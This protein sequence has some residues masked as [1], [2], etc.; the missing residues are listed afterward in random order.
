MPV[1]RDILDYF[2]KYHLPLQ[3]DLRKTFLKQQQERNC[4]KQKAEKDR[5]KKATNWQPK[6]RKKW[7]RHLNTATDNFVI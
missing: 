6:Q 1:D 5:W 3:G 2:L 4:L 7:R